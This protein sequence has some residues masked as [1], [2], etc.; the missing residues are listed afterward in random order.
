MPWPGEDDCDH[1]S[2]CGF[3]FSF[4]VLYSSAIPSRAPG[5]GRQLRHS[6]PSPPLS[7]DITST[8]AHSTSSHIQSDPEIAAGLQV[9]FYATEM[10]A[11]RR[12][13]I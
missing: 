11:G 8:D 6:S 10:R 13:G 12:A 9:S 7:R 4:D 1:P 5:R 2:S 3:F